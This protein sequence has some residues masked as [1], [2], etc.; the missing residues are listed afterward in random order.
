MVALSVPKALL[1]GNTTTNT[2]G[3]SIA[4]QRRSPVA[5]AKDG[6]TI[7]FGRFVTI[8]RMGIPAV[9]TVFIRPLQLKD[10]YDR[11]DPIDD[12]NGKFA[13]EIVAALKGLQTDDTS[14]GILA[15][16]AVVKG[17]MLR[18]RLDL[19]N[20]GQQGGMNPEAAFPNGRRPADDA[21]D[22]VI[23]LIN[24]RQPVTPSGK[25]DG[26][27]ANDVPFQDAFPFF[28]LPNMPFGVNAGADDRTRN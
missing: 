4:M 5:F 3:C 9:N 7:G 1:V 14:I 15:S 22:T 8:D 27:N 17:D 20:T 25:V 19:P 11:A 10:A 26:V 16:L 2:L 12:A 24:S 13:G 6:T 28:A 23:T 21:I 18:L